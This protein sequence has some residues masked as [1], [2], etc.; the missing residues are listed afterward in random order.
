MAC[1][2][3]IAP[4]KPQGEEMTAKKSISS[5]LNASKKCCRLIFGLLLLNIDNVSCCARSLSV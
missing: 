3:F 1:S 5:S 2:T 4:V